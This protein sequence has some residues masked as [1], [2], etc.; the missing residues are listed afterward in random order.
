M[1]MMRAR[2]V[3]LLA[4]L[5]VAGGCVSIGREF[6]T[7]TRERLVVGLTTRADLLK[8]LGPPAQVG[9]EDGDRTWTWVYVRTGV[10]RTRS[11]QLHV[12]FDERGVVKSYAYTSNLPEDVQQ[13]A[14]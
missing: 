7:P 12:R 5:L 13:A 6:P 14:R 8:L 3:G 1:G 2:R 11:K 10:G 4:I 9:I